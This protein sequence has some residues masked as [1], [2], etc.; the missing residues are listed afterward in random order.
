MTA[1]ASS[2]R[3][4][5]TPPRAGRTPGLVSFL[6]QETEIILTAG[7][8]QRVIVGA[9]ALLFW[10]GAESGP[11]TAEGLVAVHRDEIAAA[12]AAKLARGFKPR[13]D[14]IRIGEDDLD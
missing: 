3:T 9:D 11:Q 2:D 4:G 1:E 13:S 14:T 7:D 8:R 5:A 12:V 6:P 10:W